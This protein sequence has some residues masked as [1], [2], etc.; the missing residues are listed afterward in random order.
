MLDYTSIHDRPTL[1]QFIDI[2]HTIAGDGEQLMGLGGGTKA[3]TLIPRFRDIPNFVK[4]MLDSL[5]HFHIWQVSLQRSCSD[6]CQIWK[7]YLIN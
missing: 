6:T 5:Y 2:Q 3:H 4:N 7:W 1:I